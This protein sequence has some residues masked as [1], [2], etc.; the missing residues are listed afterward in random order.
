MRGEAS[1]PE[2]R[3]LIVNA[4]DLGMTS[5]INEGIFEAFEAGALRS[6]SI[7]PVMPAFEQAAC[8][9]RAAGSALG[10]GLHFTLTIG[11][12]LTHA[13]S[14]TDAGG[15]F[16][17]LPRL[18]TRLCTGRVS[19]RE[20]ASECRAQLSACRHAGL[21]PTH[22]DGH[23]H[24]HVLP[25]VREVVDAMLAEEGIRFRRL[26]V[27]RLRGSP[28]PW[29]RVPA[30]LALAVAARSGDA[31]QRRARAADAFFGLSLF[32][33]TRFAD[34]L[35]RQLDALPRGTSELMVHPG[36]VDATHPAR[37]R[38]T[39]ARE[40]EVRALTSPAVLARLRQGDIELLHFGSA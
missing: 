3:R 12:P 11:R 21:A 32:G 16:L 36:H 30:R 15:E 27:E 13:P 31:R 14:L 8:E 29:R 28:F 23:E 37:D 5:G 17:S 22:L 24:V 19:R 33:A 26:P 40:I 2:R 7:M 6:A 39:T 1:T 38:Y 25:V 4:D 10:V 34:D 9:A 35:L 18:V 20:L